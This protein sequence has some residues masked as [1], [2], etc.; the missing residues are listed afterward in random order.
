MSAYIPTVL[1]AEHAIARLEASADG[2]LYEVLNY[3]T[4]A[5]FCDG[6]WQQLDP[7]KAMRLGVSVLEHFGAVPHSACSPGDVFVYVH[8]KLL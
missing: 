1:M 5:L 6:V 4:C 7:E 2:E 8:N 3:T